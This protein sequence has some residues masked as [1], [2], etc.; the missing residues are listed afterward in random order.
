VPA[1]RTDRG[2][3]DPVDI[4]RVVVPVDGS[5]FAERALPVAVWAAHALGA[6]IHLIEVVPGARDTA[7]AIRYLDGLTRRHAVSRW[8]VA[9]GDDVGDTIVAATRGE[10]P[11]ACLATHGRDRRATV[12]GST[13]IAVLDRATDPV[14][15]VGP[16]ARPPRAGD[17]PVVVAVDGTATDH[18]LVAI[19]QGWGHAWATG[20]SSP[21]WPNRCPHRFV[22]A[23]P[24]IGPAG[25]PT[26]RATSPPWRRAPPTRAAPLTP[27]WL[28]TP[29]ACATAWSGSST[30]PRHCWWSG[31]TAGRDLGAHC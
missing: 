7:S 11:A 18:A 22:R 19:A 30:A 26:P 10:P 31:R 5:P 1:E 25:R 3:V 28:T 20:S 15:L 23:S 4:G 29:S 24:S 16:Q 21:R 27:G 6:E 9:R 2:P 17:A 13:A 8:D 12:L 14:M